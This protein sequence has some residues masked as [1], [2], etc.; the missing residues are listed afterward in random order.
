M[1]N[2]YNKPGAKNVNITNINA[3]RVAM[4][5]P[6]SL[7]PTSGLQKCQAGIETDEKGIGF[8]DQNDVYYSVYP[9]SGTAN[10]L[11]KISENGI[12]AIETAFTEAD[13]T[14]LQILLNSKQ[15]LDSDLTAI[16]ALTHSSGHVMI[17]NGT[18]WTRRALLESDIPALSIGK[19]TNLQTS[20]DGKAASVHNHIIADVTNLQGTL[21]GKQQLDSDLTAIA[22]LTHSTGHVIISNG[23]MWTRRALMESDIPALSISKITNLQPNLDGKV[24]HTLYQ[25]WNTATNCFNNNASNGPNGVTNF[26]GL[27]IKMAGNDYHFQLL[28]R[29][30]MFYVRTK[31]NGTWYP[32]RTLWHDG[33]FNP[34]NYSLTSH[35]LTGHSDWSTYFNGQALKTT[36]IPTFAG[37]YIP[38]GGVINDW[39]MLGVTNQQSS[40][41]DLYWYK[42]YELT[43]TGRADEDIELRVHGDV[44]YYYGHCI[45]RLKMTRYSG[46]PAN[47]LHVT[48]T[49]VSGWPSNALI[50]ING[51]TVWVASAVKWGDIYGRLAQSRYNPG[52]NLFSTAFVTAT[53]AGTDLNGTFGVKNWDG[54]AQVVRYHNID[55]ANGVFT[56]NIIVGSTLTSEGKYIR[57]QS[58]D[59]YNCGFE[60]FGAY[61]GT[62]YLYLGQ[63]ST[64]GGG[65]YYQGDGTPAWA[66]G[67]LID[68]VNF[69]RRNNGQDEV[70][71]YYPYSNNNVYF[72]GAISTNNIANNGYTDISNGTANHHYRD[73]YHF[74]TN[75]ASITGTMKIVLPKTW[76]STMIVLKI[77]GY[78]YT[79]S[80]A[81]EC[82]ISGYNFS[83]TGAWFN[84]SAFIKGS[85]PF[86]SV[87]LAHDG[88]K[89]CLLLGNTSTV[90][91]Y[92]QIE[93]TD[94]Y[95]SYSNQTGWG[96]PYSMAFVTS[97]SGIT[98]IVTPVLNSGVS[99]D[100]NALINKPI[101]TTNYITKYTNGATGAVGNSSI[102]DNGTIV[103]THSI[104]SV[105]IAP[106]NNQNISFAASDMFTIMP[107]EA[108]RQS[109]YLNQN[110][111]Y[112]GSTWRYRK[113]Y[114]ASFIAMASD[115][116]LVFYNAPN[117]AAG[118]IISWEGPTLMLNGDRSI[119]AIGPFNLTDGYGYLQLY[120]NSGQ[121]RSMIKAY[122]NNICFA[123]ETADLYERDVLVIHR[124][125]GLLGQEIPLVDISGILT[126]GNDIYT[127]GDI[128]VDGNA[129]VEENVIH[130][131]GFI[132]GDAGVLTHPYPGG[133]PLD[134]TGY[135]VVNLT[136]SGGEQ[137]YTISGGISGQRLAIV[138]SSPVNHAV[139]NTSTTINPGVFMDFIRIG[140]TWYRE[141]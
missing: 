16:A 131:G 96:S 10:R 42:A 74:W 128:F 7:L 140:G 119:E 122:G 76:S 81:W 77:T 45:V 8:K 93:V 6:A 47:Q 18:A 87:R 23:T 15:P 114:G 62:G 134:V 141:Y 52:R 5:A 22:A 102:I 48:V 26:M 99:A 111:Y 78:N 46:E 104:L 88:S 70:V 1:Q 51:G 57:V 39:T 68:G 72:R 108:N 103:N 91:T 133:L 97:E 83:G 79:S 64:Y 69:Y 109:T 49:P 106:A 105:G 90:W 54:D 3:T 126:V 27:D 92:P 37:I 123:V 94:V 117:G 14:N 24:S 21:D 56:G 98:N 2:T 59:N 127:D 28:G 33:N 36:S 121:G 17:S 29:Q 50:K 44:S 43:G 110:A 80:G 31:E 116:K 25:D 9:I 136:Y 55:G 129:T 30:D 120:N 35:L 66:T 137:N 135:S 65:L 67:E 138:N 19:I 13:I 71:F 115:G 82:V 20:L 75:T 100:W 34:D 112:D 53:P 130:N 85:A 125:A 139:T 95:C 58:G 118:N 107:W 63:S 11:L 113:A 32:Y 124:D 73:V 86:S 60:A 4:S 61:N 84:T 38:N 40:P 89:C 132:Y 41:Y 12:R 101:G